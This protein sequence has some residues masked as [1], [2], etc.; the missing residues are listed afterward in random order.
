ME[1]KLKQLQAKLEADVNL[2]EKIFNQET[3][4]QVQAV[5]KEEG[6]EFS[7]EEINQLKE[8]VVKALEKTSEA[9][10]ELS[11]EDLED[12]AGGIVFTAAGVAA[13][14]AVAGAVIAGISAIGS[15]TGSI[16]R[17]RW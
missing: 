1:E 15:I 2:V 13:G 5:L 12:V 11:D 8:F 7:L 9:D 14:A 6:L 10:G 3:P 16:V 4:E 17:D